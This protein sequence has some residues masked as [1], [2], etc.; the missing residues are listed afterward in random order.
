MRKLMIPI[1]LIGSMFAFGVQ[2]SEE[3]SGDQA[4]NETS[5]KSEYSSAIQ[6]PNPFEFFNWSQGADQAQ[7]TATVQMRPLDPAFWSDF[8][9]PETHKKMHM[10]FM[11][12]AQ[13]MQ[14]MQPQFFAQFMNP[15]NF[16][17]MMNPQSYAVFMNPNTWT[18][19]MQPDSYMHF[20]DM[21]MYSQVMNPAS[22]M[23]FMNPALY[24]QWMDPSAYAQLVPDYMASADVT[25][26]SSESQ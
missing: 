14:M 11:N 8:A 15:A 3:T 10:A 2:A 21:N 24:A 16:M 19:W 17:A 22:F 26:D 9:R 7:A 5:V 23:N 4:N 1:A 13:Y 12:P 20:M 25:A 6:Q 18:S